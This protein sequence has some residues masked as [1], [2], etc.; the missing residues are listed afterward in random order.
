MDALDILIFGAHADDAEIGMGGTIAKHVEAGYRV[1]VCDLT[2][3][4]MSS[5]GTV[6][7]RRREAAEASAVLGLSSRTNLQ[8]PD[9]GLDGSPH[10]I[11]AIVVEIRRTKPRLVFAP[12]WVDRHPD[13]VSCSKLIEEAVFNSK[14]R[15]YMS[16]LPP[17]QVTELIYY[18]INDSEEVSLTVDITASYEKKRRALQAYRS[19]FERSASAES[20]ETPLTQRYV[21]RVEA[22]D[23][24][25]GQRMGCAY[26]EG[27]A[28][29]RPHGIALF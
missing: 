16:E 1:G 7:L 24:L 29:K 28:I 14:L 27:F 23:S 6:E 22:R 2:Q 9:R 20:V 12:Y 17:V 18:Y 19:Q 13:H 10:Q 15:N 8:L 4:E 25:L 5:N 21:E 26:A 11:E 3:A